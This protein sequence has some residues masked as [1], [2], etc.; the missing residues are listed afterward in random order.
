MLLALG[1]VL[2]VVPQLSTP[3]NCIRFCDFSHFEASSDLR[4]M[5]L[6][7]PGKENSLTVEVRRRC[8]PSP[9]DAV[10]VRACARPRTHTI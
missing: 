8:L 5:Q 4:V 3:P 7:A 1:C 6:G 9:G 10:R 2:G